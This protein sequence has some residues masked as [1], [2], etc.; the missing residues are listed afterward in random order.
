[1]GIR[2]PNL[3]SNRCEGESNS[4][5]LGEFLSK[6][7]LLLAIVDLFEQCRMA[8]DELIDV[9]WTPHHHPGRAGVIGK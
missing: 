7:G 8:C 9:R 3:K 5:K 4:W 2:L 6:S 1:M